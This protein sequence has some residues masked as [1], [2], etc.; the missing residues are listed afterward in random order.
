MK[1]VEDV[2]VLLANRLER[3]VLLPMLVE[4]GWVYL[5]KMHIP[6]IVLGSRMLV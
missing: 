1:G 4:M 6:T 5:V 2:D 3:C